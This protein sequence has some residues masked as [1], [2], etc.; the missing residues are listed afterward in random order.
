MK[1]LSDVLFGLYRGT[2]QH[3]EWV[4]ACLE[5]AW[6]AL[7]GDRLAG[8]CRPKRLE[9]GHLII[10]ISDRTWADALRGMQSELCDKIRAAT[11]DEVRQIAF[12][13]SI[14]PENQS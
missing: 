9:K 5:G 6:P 3:E 10:E 7:V 4:I 12:R 11:R 8:V 2:P 1:P 14:D 13:A